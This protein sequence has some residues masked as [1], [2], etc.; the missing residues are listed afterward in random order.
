MSK[1][2]IQSNRGDGYQTLVAL[3]WALTVLSDPAYQWLEVDTVRW[4]VDDVVIGKHDGSVI[5]CQCKKNLQG[6][7]S[8]TITELTAELKT[9]GSLL[10]SDAS[11][12]VKFYSRS[13]FGELNVLREFSTNYADYTSYKSALPIGHRK[14]DGKL[15]TVLANSP[16]ASTFE[17]LRRTTFEVSPDFDRMQTLV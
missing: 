16:L 5:C 4:L 17:F 15:H 1:A 9:A 2:G 14:I 6:F 3:D 7:N 12:V 11:A 8:W 13:P 10:G